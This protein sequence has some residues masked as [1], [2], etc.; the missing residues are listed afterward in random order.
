MGHEKKSAGWGYTREGRW[1]RWG[2]G[3]K[4]I[5]EGEKRRRWREEWR[6]EYVLQ[7]TRQRACICFTQAL[8]HAALRGRYMGSR[9]PCTEWCCW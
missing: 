3:E 6:G 9:V 8:S 2:A 1:G 5:G 7:G 4:K